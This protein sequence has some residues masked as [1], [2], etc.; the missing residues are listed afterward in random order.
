MVFLMYFG[1]LASQKP[2]KYVD[3]CWLFITG[4][5]DVSCHLG[6]RKRRQTGVVAI[7]L[8]CHSFLVLYLRPHQDPPNPVTKSCY[9]S[10]TFQILPRREVSD[11]LVEA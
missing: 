11:G 2:A 8:T 9:E 4:Q 10:P 6:L 7:R 1:R 5:G 3:C